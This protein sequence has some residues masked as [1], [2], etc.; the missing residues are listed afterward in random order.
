MVLIQVELLSGYSPVADS[1]DE[2]RPQVCVQLGWEWWQMCVVQVSMQN[3]H[4][5]C[6]QRNIVLFLLV[7]LYTQSLFQA[8]QSSSPFLP[9]AFSYPKH[10]LSHM[11][12]LPMLRSNIP[13]YFCFLIEFF[14]LFFFQLKKMPLVKKV[15]SEADRVVLYLEEV[16]EFRLMS[17]LRGLWAGR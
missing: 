12:I 15:E 16:S 3:H 17:S 14:W 8:T 13:E 5:F 7:G 1:L 2:V 9:T 4:H 6:G 10:F 11:N